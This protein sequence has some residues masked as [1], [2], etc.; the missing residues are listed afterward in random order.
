MKLKL[1]LIT[2][3]LSAAFACKPANIDQ[4]TTKLAAHGP[5]DRPVLTD[6][7]KPFIECLQATKKAFWDSYSSLPPKY[8][9][10]IQESR[11]HLNFET[12]AHISLVKFG[13]VES[14]F[15]NHACFNQF[16]ENVSFDQCYI[17]ISNS[18]AGPASRQD[19]AVKCLDHFTGRMDKY[20]CGSLV[21]FLSGLKDKYQK[22]CDTL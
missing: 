10:C 19:L 3:M 6:D 20:Q 18:N 7:H 2:A 17:L 4:E 15:I 13:R 12:C 8:E 11:F 21:P 1:F 9:K 16:K 5:Q 22:L 14:T